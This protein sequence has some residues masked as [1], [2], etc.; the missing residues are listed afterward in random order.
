MNKTTT[1]TI[2]SILTLV[3]GFVPVT[4]YAHG[5]EHSEEVF[6]PVEKEFG[7]Y[8]PDLAATRTI[9]IEMSDKMRFTPDLVKVKKGEVIKFVHTNVGQI[10]HEF[11][12]GTPDILA[13]HYEVMKKF[14]N[15]EHSEPYMLHVAPGKTGSLVW[16]FSKAGEF[17]FGCLIPG[18]FDAGM[19][20]TVV[21]DS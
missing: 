10:K 11:V 5:E 8:D 14:P 9:E 17:A 15:M 18:H 6:D 1:T 3:F 2:A 7:S 20:G 21:V 16:Q 19:K 13:E 4:V 12:L